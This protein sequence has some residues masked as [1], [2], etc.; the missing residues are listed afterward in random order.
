MPGF[1]AAATG[2]LVFTGVGDWRGLHQQ[3]LALPSLPAY[4]SV[5]V[6]DLAW[7]IA[8]SVVIAGLVVGIR[9]LAHEVAARAKPR[10]VLALVVAGALVGVIA[11]A[12]RAAADRP[13]D[14][15][16]FSGQQ[17]MP[18]VIAEGSASVLLLLVV[19]KGL[20]YALS[21]GAGFRGGPV[22]PA[23]A[24]GVALGMVGADV[25]PGLEH[26]AGGGDRARGGDSGRPA[27]AVH[28]RT[29]R[30]APPGLVCV[31]RDADRG[32]RGGRRPGSS[33][34]PSRTRRTGYA[35][36]RTRQ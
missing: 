5:R 16:L 35:R 10:P 29:A 34:W 2:A 26:H 30:D 22:F 12:F 15:V 14:L 28:R 7:G 8:L 19:A 23:L 25:L 21:L 20:A 27:R 32:V 6:A 3:D 33:L 36:P 18:D 31:R 24:I 11:V 4:D 9:H 17:E 13:V 1:V